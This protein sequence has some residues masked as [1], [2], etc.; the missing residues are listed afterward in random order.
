MN[1]VFIYNRIYFNRLWNSKT[2]RTICTKH[3]DRVCSNLQNYS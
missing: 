3:R 2:V 1:V